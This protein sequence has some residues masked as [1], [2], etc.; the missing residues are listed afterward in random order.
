MQY[1]DVCGGV[2]LDTTRV[3]VVKHERGLSIDVTVL[4]HKAELRRL[5]D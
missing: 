1:K 3:A 5:V 4:R 2:V